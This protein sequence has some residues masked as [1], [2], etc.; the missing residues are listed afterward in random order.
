M[1]RHFLCAYFS[2]TA[3]GDGRF[4]HHVALLQNLVRCHLASIGDIDFYDQSICK[5]L[6]IRNT[7]VMNIL[8]KLLFFSEFSIAFSLALVCREI[9]AR[10]DRYAISFEEAWV[11][12]AVTKTG[13]NAPRLCAAPAADR[14]TLCACAIRQRIENR[15]SRNVIF[16]SMHGNR[17]IAL[18]APPITMIIGSSSKLHADPGGR[19]FTR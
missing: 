10:S 18:H 9:L 3:L 14:S 19:V 16:I 2:E 17:T 6:T 8:C 15:Y 13:H 12:C 11:V 7:L 5:I 4:L 1:E